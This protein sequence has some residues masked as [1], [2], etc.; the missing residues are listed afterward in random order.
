MSDVEAAATIA[1]DERAGHEETDAADPDRKRVLPGVANV[2][3]RFRSAE[4]AGADL[5]MRVVVDGDRCDGR[6]DQEEKCD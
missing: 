3:H 4:E 1:V 6:D 5:P 2:A